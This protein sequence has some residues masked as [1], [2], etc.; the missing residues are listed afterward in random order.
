[1]EVAGGARSSIEEL[2]SSSILSVS[3]HV[4]SNLGYVQNKPC[5]EELSRKKRKHRKFDVPDG[6]ENHEIE[7]STQ[8]QEL[9]QAEPLR[10]SCSLHHMHNLMMIRC[11]IYSL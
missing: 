3:T 7:D 10:S 9:E 11:F 4:S 8:R 6:Q 2:L 1:M 5:K